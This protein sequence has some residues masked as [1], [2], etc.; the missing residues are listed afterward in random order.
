MTIY[1]DEEWLGV[2]DDIVYVNLQSCV[3]LAVES[4]NAN[5]GGMHMTVGTKSM[6]M[7]RAGTILLGN[8]GGPVTQVYCVGNL[9]SFKT[10]AD[11]A[12]HYKQGLGKT[13]REVL[14]W[15]GVIYGYDTSN[16]YNQGGGGAY[17][18]LVAR[19]W[20]PQGTANVSIAVGPPSAWT[21]AGR[22]VVNDPIYTAR[23]TLGQQSQDRVHTWD[24]ATIRNM[25]DKP[26]NTYTVQQNNLQVL[27]GRD[28][29]SF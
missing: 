15:T 29:K 14:N 13:L 5:L 28:F 9:A 16:I 7:Q 17:N 23:T 18:G 25:K 26:C 3:A 8:L 1:L 2:A 21:M 24:Q 10:A 12:M 27:T 4:A 19:L 6:I 22:A 11:G 20:R